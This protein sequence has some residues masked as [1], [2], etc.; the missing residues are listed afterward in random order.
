MIIFSLIA[1]SLAAVLFWIPGLYLLWRIPF[2]SGERNGHEG[3][4][5]IIP[6]R[7]EAGNL[8]PLLESLRSQLL[9]RDEI[10]VVNDHSRDNTPEIALNHGA[11]VMGS[12]KRPDGWTGKTWACWQGAQAANNEM[13]LFVDADTW[14]AQG[15]LTRMVATLQRKNGLVSVQ[16]FHCMKKAYERLSALFNLMVMIGVDAF[17]FG[18]TNKGPSGSFGPCILCSKKDYFTVGGHKSVR[19][20]VLENLALGPL[21]KKSGFQISCFGGAHTIFF[22]MYSDGLKDLVEGW[23]KGFAT[24]AARTPPRIMALTIAWISGAFIAAIVVAV[25]ILVH[26]LSA[27]AVAAFIYLLYAGQFYWMLRRIGNFGIL[28]CL[29]FPLHL[30]FFVLIYIRSF[31]AIF[32]RKSVR[33]KGRNLSMGK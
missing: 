29:F 17:T 25:A 10:L 7:D 27:M 18:K 5:I 19:N 26:T 15:A 16:P 33:W 31:I 28:T 8:P 3:C 14:F 4:T 20:L 23:T 24:G 1:A 6:A 30:L 12:G 32:I 13:M 11:R 22:R 9:P 21:F 2:C